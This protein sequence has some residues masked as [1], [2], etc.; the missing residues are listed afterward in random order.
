MKSKIDKK[1][2]RLCIKAVTGNINEDEKK[3][4]DKW[5]SESAENKNEFERIRGIW[6]KSELR[7]FPKLPDAAD[8]WIE[9]DARIRDYADG[10]KSKTTEYLK[11]KSRSMFPSGFRFKPLLSAALVIIFFISI[12]LL[13]NMEMGKP[14]LK[15]IA[16][17]NKQHRE[18]NLSDGTHLLLNSGSSIRFPESFKE[19]RKISLRGEAFFSVA[20]NKRPFIILTDN[21]TITVLGT[22][23][24]VRSRDGKTQVYVKDGKVNLS[25]Q[26]LDNSGVVLTRGELSSVI[27]NGIPAP[28]VKADP[29]PQLGWMEGKLVFNHTPL[30][31]IIEDIERFYD[32][33]IFLQGSTLNS[34]SMTGSFKNSKLDNVLNM[35]CLALDLDYSKLP[36]KEIHSSNEK[37]QYI[38]KVKKF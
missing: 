25:Q 24:N 16:T 37:E 12:M 8:E 6:I 18:I 15:L 7:D 29:D 14:D 32:V 22:K 27:K 11:I 3:F 5:L 1:F 34:Y 9:L 23:F 10:K 28:P 17:Q 21:A 2:S 35:I 19:E 36:A 4:L 33:E 31:E 13:W 20:K 26:N 30:A 38:I